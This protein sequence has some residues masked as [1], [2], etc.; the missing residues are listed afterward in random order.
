M[1][2]RQL[3]RAAVRQTA[4]E[5][6][7]QEKAPSGSPIAGGKAAQSGDYFK[8]GICS[9]HLV[10]RNED[11]AELD[12]LKSDLRAEHQPAN[13]T[14]EILVNEMAEQFWR[15]RRFRNRE[16]C[17]MV[18]RRPRRGAY[19][20]L[21]VVPVIQRMM[22]GAERGFHKALSA[23]RLLLWLRPTKRQN[24][25]GAAHGVSG[26]STDSCKRLPLYWPITR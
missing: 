21:K 15:I 11:P 3:R 9:R 17:Y 12:A 23:L 22:A 8:H 20:E 4:K 18:T 1:Q 10:I 7:K 19:A 24:R 6:R 26:P 25:L 13:T 2:T 16:N 5:T 14:E